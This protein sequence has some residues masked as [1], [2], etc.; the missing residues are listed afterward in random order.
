MFKRLRKALRL[1]PSTFRPASS[2][3]IAEA[4]EAKEVRESQK[5]QQQNENCSGGSTGK[6]PNSEKHVSFSDSVLVKV[7][8]P[9][10][11]SPISPSCNLES[12]FNFPKPPDE[13]SPSI[14]SSSILARY[15]ASSESTATSPETQCNPKSDIFKGKPLEQRMKMLCEAS[16]VSQ[17]IF[18]APDSTDD[19]VESS[20][21]CCGHGGDSNELSVDV[22]G[23]CGGYDHDG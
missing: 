9:S 21:Q 23:A 14:P 19:Q 4:C 15:Y 13:Q 16:L 1:T 6:E 7:R 18:T 11:I 5:V 10:P 22:A 3:A 8:T 17:G 12:G 2:A 20:D